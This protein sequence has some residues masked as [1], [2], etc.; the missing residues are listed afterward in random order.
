MANLYLNVNMLLTLDSN[1]LRESLLKKKQ[2][3]IGEKMMENV[4]GTKT[5]FGESVA[6]CEYAANFTDVVCLLVQEMMDMHN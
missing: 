5:L 3:P 6:E 2:S 4:D 1:F